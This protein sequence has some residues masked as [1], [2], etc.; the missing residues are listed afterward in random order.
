MLHFFD[1]P[2]A[3]EY[4]VEIEHLDVNMTEVYQFYTQ[5]II[6]QQ[7]NDAQLGAA[8]VYVNGEFAATTEY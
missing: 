3:T 2:K 1:I 8:N 4:L 7:L 5:A 6:K